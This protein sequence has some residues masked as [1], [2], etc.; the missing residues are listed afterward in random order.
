MRL[1]TIGLFVILTLVL[2]AVSLPAEAKQAGSNNRATR[3]SS[4]DFNFDSTFE[5]GI[6][7]TR[8]AGGLLFQRAV[9]YGP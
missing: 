7:D 9:L 5:Q 3:F 1:R 8:E 4:G 6:G 2:L